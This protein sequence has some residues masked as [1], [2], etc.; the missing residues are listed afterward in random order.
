MND[1]NVDPKKILFL[2]YDNTQTKLIDAIIKAGCSVDH[3]DNAFNKYDYDLV[4][5]F[6]YAYILS[7]EVIEKFACPILNLHMSY[8]PFNRGAH[9]NFW[10]HYD[11]TPCGVTIHLID[12]GIDTGPI[13]AQRKTKFNKKLFTFRQ[14]YIQ[15]KED[16]EQLFLENLKILL[17]GTWKAKPQKGNGTFHRT[18]DL[19]EQFIGWDQN[20]H[21]EIS[22]LKKLKE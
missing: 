20:I 5:S 7:K 11:E 13:I 3:S 15:L 9:P 19:P 6:G 14:T 17:Y 22:R 8:L 12:G 1:S 10:S 4:I 2:G 16:L 18:R 21:H